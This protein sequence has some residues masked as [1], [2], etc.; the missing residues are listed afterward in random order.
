MAYLGRRARFIAA[1]YGADAQETRLRLGAEYTALNGLGRF[2]RVLLWFEH[3]LWDQAALIRVL[4]LLAERRGLEGRLFLLPADGAR[5]FVALTDAELGA[6]EPQP[7]T[8]A[9][10]ES[11]ALAWAAF[12]AEDPRGLDALWRRPTPLP[13]LAA[14]LHRHL[15]DLPWTVDG[16]A[17]TERLLLRAIADGAS[18]GSSILGAMQR[19]DPVFQV[20]DLMVRDI[21]S[22]L[23]E[24]PRR[25]IARDAWALTARGEAVLRGEERHLPS[26]R[27]LGGVT[28]GPTA[29]WRWDAQ[30]GR[31]AS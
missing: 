15:L 31:V 9:Q 1:H 7:L 4:S 6:L 3:D 8:R 16:L 19:A 25:L 28:L 27:F 11:G 26:P 18:S 20:T 22:R 23:S 2:D 13:H 17:L 29:P 30:L 5:P 12:A 14:A 10:L 24:G 21:R